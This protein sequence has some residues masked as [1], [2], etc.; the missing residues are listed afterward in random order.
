MEAIAIGLTLIGQIVIPIAAAAISIAVGIGIKWLKN[1]IQ[2]EEGKQAL[3]ALDQIVSTTV[4]NIAQTTRQ[5]M[6]REAKK[7]KLSLVQAADLKNAALARIK[8]VASHEIQLAASKMVD[9]L[10][11]YVNQK[12]EDCVLKLK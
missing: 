5:D 8:A 10:D 12:I 6:L 11:G 3:D 9:D 4:G 2:F 1:K 7:A